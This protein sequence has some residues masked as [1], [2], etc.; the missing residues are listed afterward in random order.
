MLARAQRLTTHLL[1][2]SGRRSAEPRR[3]RLGEWMPLIVEIL[4]SLMP[5]SIRIDVSIANDVADVEVDPGEF[6]SALLNVAANARDAMPS[7]GRL[8]IRASN[9][10]CAKGGQDGEGHEARVV[11]AVSDEGEGIAAENLTKVFEPFFT[12]KEPGKGTG[13][14]L[15][16]VHGFA[17]ASGGT[18]SVES[19]PGRGTTVTLRL[20]VARGNA[21]RLAPEA[22]D[23]Q[24]AAPLER[25]A[26]VLVVDDNRDVAEATGALLEQIGYSVCYAHDAHAA[27]ERVQL[28]PSPRLVVSDVVMPGAVDGVGLA[29]LLRRTR[30]D[31][32]VI[33][34][35]GFSE[36]ARQATDEGLQVLFKP[37]DPEV[38]E[39]MVRTALGESRVIPFARR[40]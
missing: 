4:R 8:R 39:R 31:L 5:E 21:R 26:L 9:E 33:L 7:G 3:I 38:L 30:P 40:S 15:S 14:G 20:P 29:R 12:T 34:C 1:S 35:T 36:Q 11:V 6:E 10:M 18:V 13:L 25:G 19:E 2:V 22:D 23:A 27:L 24:A 37:I 32:P 16:Q 28:E 17:R